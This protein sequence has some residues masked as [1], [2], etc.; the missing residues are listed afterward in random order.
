MNI[1]RASMYAISA[2]VQLSKAP[3]GIPLSC[4]HMAKT[5]EMPTRF[6]LQVMRNLV[7]HGLVKSTRGVNGGYTLSRISSE[8]SLL[9]ILEAVDG[10]FIA[11]LPPFECIPRE[12]QVN[13]ENILRQ[14]MS[15]TSRRLSNVSLE[16][17]A[18]KQTM[19][20]GLDCDE[21]QSI[22]QDC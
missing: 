19:P 10:P 2:L 21:R 15:N 3:P 4:N 17:L 6:L 13:I 11:T 18:L 12:C 7:N 5:G 9:Q 22:E 1:S 14:I 8:I 16:D 20:A